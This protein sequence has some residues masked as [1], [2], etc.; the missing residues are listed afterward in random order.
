MATKKKR[1]KKPESYV[2]ITEARHRW[3]CDM[4]AIVDDLRG[5]LGGG[6][7]YPDNVKL[8]K[9]LVDDSKASIQDWPYEG[10][11]DSNGEPTRAF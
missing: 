4:E 7:L 5:L 1:K 10:P 6:N 2:V 11:F 3:L 9:R 8:A